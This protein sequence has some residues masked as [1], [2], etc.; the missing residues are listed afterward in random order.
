MSEKLKAHNQ[1]KRKKKF[2]LRQVVGPIQA[3]VGI[4]HDVI[5]PQNTQ[6]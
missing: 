6:K 2:A 5:D 1:K 4:G 3:V